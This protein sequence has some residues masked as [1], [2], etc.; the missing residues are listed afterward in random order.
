[1]LCQFHPIAARAFQ[2]S[3]RSPNFFARPAVRLGTW[4]TRIAVGRPGSETSSPPTQGGSARRHADTTR[5]SMPAPALCMCVLRSSRPSIRT[6]ST[7]GLSSFS[8][9]VIVLGDA[10]RVPAEAGQRFSYK[11]AG[12]SN[13]RSTQ[14]PRTPSPAAPQERLET[15]RRFSIL[16]YNQVEAINWLTPAALR[17]GHRDN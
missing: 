4:E 6:L 1:M 12:R 17:L 13:M 11:R 7:I 2:Q 14:R 10:I 16:D 3:G 15:E 5:S 8:R 9:G